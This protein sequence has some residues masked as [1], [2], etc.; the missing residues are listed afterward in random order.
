M[1]PNSGGSEIGYLTARIS[2]AP[3]A[4]PLPAAL[5]LFGSG[6]GAMGI[7]ARRRKA[8]ACAVAAA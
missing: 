1:G 3:A 6:L 2:E 5:V 8:K 7:F 4:T